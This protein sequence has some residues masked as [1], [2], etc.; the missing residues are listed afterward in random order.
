M[1]NRLG[2]VVFAL[3]VIAT[4]TSAQERGGED[5]TGPYQIVENWLQPVHPGWYHHATG[6]YAESPNRILIS[7]S[8]ET[9]IPETKPGER[10]S[11]ASIKGF[12]PKRPGA[13]ADHF[14][15]VV[16]G[17][18]RILE[19]WTQLLKLA[20]RPH[21]VTENPYDPD[22]HVWIIDREGQQ[23]IELSHDGK[24]VVMTIGEKGVAGV[25]EKHFN[26][27]A[28]M[29]FLPDGSFFVADGYINTRIIKFDKNGKYLTQ[30]GNPGS[31]PGEFN[32][33]HCVAVDAQGRVY[34]AD[35]SNGRIQVFDSK[36]KYL[37]EWRSRRPTFLMVTQ[38]QSLWVA[39]SQADR[40]LKYDLNGKLLTYW[41]VNGT[42][43]GAMDDPHSF[44]VDSDGNL[45][46]VDYNNN[47]V[48]K[49]RPRPGADPK[50]LIGQPYRAKG[51]DD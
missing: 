22:K 39:D 44:S 33:V 38:D 42:F 47:R 7:A 10:R 19:E 25:D 27:P 13:K 23:V 28:N 24:S 45:Y 51:N 49:Y 36:G 4:A 20:V 2:R 3:L 41:G 35:R 17:N 9:P 26:R 30:W 15:I 31:G 43:P 34:V 6:V 16:D 48:Q 18:G 50:R 12:D 14:L 5:E 37:E 40:I 46:V 1:N 21:S 29:A 11:G 8:G 32:L